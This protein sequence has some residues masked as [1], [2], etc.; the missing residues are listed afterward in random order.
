MELSTKSIAQA[1]E[2]RYRN[3]RMP[4][5]QKEELMLNVLMVSA[6]LSKLEGY[7]AV[8]VIGLAN[9]AYQLEITTQ[10]K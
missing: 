5:E 2:D 4:R 10:N 3:S 9:D 7:K 6:L 1:F 8:E